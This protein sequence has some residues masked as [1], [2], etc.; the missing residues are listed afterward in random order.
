VFAVVQNGTG[1]HESLHQAIHRQLKAD[2]RELAGVLRAHGV[3]AA[4]L[5]RTRAAAVNAADPFPAGDREAHLQRRLAAREERA[6]RLRS[7]IRGLELA[8]QPLTVPT[9]VSSGS[10]SLVGSYA[11]SIAERYLGVR[12]VWGGSDPSSGFDCSGFMTYVYAYLGIRLPHYAASQYA[13]TA[14][15]DPSQLQPGDLVFF[16][17][18]ADGPGHVGMYVGSGLFIEAP[19][20]GDVVKLASLSTEASL[21]GFVGASRPTA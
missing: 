16:E 10:S 1:P 9:A 20:T 8:L 11:V 3:D 5:R 14:H 2:Q 21:M 15:V 18:K 13:T 4:L 6:Q 7:A 19:H 17:P 12:Y